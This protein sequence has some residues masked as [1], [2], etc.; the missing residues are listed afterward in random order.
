MW[1]AREKK[2]DEMGPI[3]VHVRNVSIARH[4]HRM[5][6]TTI[7]ICQSYTCWYAHDEP[8]VLA[9]TMNFSNKS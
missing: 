4:C 7:W 5:M 8:L 6:Y 3:F 9:L 1:G 2:R